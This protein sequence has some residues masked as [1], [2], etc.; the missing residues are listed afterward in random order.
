MLTG[1]PVPV[2]AATPSRQPTQAQRPGLIER[3]MVSARRPA[4]VVLAN[5]GAGWL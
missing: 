2:L 1:S 4:T 5:I 3:M